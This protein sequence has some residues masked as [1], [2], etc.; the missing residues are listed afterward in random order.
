MNWKYSL[1][2][3]QNCKLTI[4]PQMYQAVEV[5]QL[6]L[7]ELINYINI[8][9]AENPLLEVLEYNQEENPENE[10]R[11]EDLLAKQLLE[12]FE[13]EREDWLTASPN[14][15]RL[16]AVEGFWLDNSTLQEYLMEQL[17]FV[18]H[19]SGMSDRDYSIAEYIIGNLDNNGY[20]SSK[21]EDLA[22]NLK[23]SC[24]EIEKA[25]A[26]VQKLDPPG[27]GAKNLQEC[28]KLQLSLIP[29]CPPE[30]EELLKY[31]DDLAAGYFKKIASHLNI[32]VE[33]VR[34][35]AKFL[36]MLDPKPGSRFSGRNSIRY[37]V[38][39]ATIKKVGEEFV[40]IVNDRDL[41]KLYINETYRKVLL[42]QDSPE[43]KKYVREKINAANTLIKSIEQRKMTVFQVIR[44]AAEK[45]RDFLE[46]GISGL[47]PLTMKQIADEL[48]IHESTVSRAAANKYIQTPRGMYS[49]KCFFVGSIGK[50]KEITAEKIKE[51]LK[52]MIAAE[53]PL[54]PY[55]DKELAAVLKGKG[56]TVSRRTIAKY[57][58]EL[59]IPSTVFRKRNTLK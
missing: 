51:E 59:G 5:L 39:D 49:L 44:A 58:D 53:D 6:S 54:K 3:E 50:K 22:D 52:K 42:E 7:P 31:L 27:I 8:Q 33:K 57:R 1:I 11:N 25:L 16:N 55:S 13:D 19:T 18:R 21:L 28:L 9:L 47:T 35:L 30:M 12:M 37:I 48:G 36:K 24:K 43:I 40:V 45:Q 41:P 10:D 46:E 23:V 15:T 34:K 56:I 32:P 20:L 29:D 2:T 14:E 38:P 26:V 4:T 17:R